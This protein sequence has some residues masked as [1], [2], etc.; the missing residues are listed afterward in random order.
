MI[1][2]CQGQTELSS[3]SSQR[4]PVSSTIPNRTRALC[5]PVGSVYV[6]VQFV[7]GLEFLHR[8]GS[9]AK[10]DQSFICAYPALR[11]GL[12]GRLSLGNPPALK[13]SVWVHREASLPRTGRYQQGPA[14]TRVSR[15]ETAISSHTPGTPLAPHRIHSISSFDS[16]SGCPPLGTTTLVSETLPDNRAA[17]CWL[18]RR[19][20]SSPSSITTS[21]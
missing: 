13:Q 1:G 14:G 10:R 11:E 17:S 4:R 3:G 21:C 12:H 20:A 2:I 6:F 18:A 5:T 9:T 15:I 16:W 7:F 19:P 8:L